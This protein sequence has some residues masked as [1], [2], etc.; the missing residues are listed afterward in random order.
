MLLLLLL[1]SLTINVYVVVVVVAIAQPFGP[2]ALATLFLLR[3]SQDTHT[4]KQTNTHNP[5]K[6]KRWR[7]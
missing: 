1:H 2:P 5:Q 3:L 4:H 7:L 6:N